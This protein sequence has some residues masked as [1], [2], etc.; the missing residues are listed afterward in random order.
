MRCVLGSSSRFLPYKYRS[1]SDSFLEMS[2]D[3]KSLDALPVEPPSRVKLNLGEINPLWRHY[4]IKLSWALHRNHIMTP[5]A[6]S[7]S[8]ILSFFFL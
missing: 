6:D 8:L 1:I 4:S 2:L 7:F 5:P 3:L